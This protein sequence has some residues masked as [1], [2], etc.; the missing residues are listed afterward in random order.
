MFHPKC[1]T[2]PTVNQNNADR[3]ESDDRP[4]EQQQQA[5]NTDC[6]G[7]ENR[8]ALFQQK[9]KLALRPGIVVHFVIGL[10]A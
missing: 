3:E 10:S 6:C 9:L 2:M 4:T 7:V 8:R 5:C 1:E